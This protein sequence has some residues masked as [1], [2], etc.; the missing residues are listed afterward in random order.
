MRVIAPLLTIMAL[1]FFPTY[2]SFGTQPDNLI[3][4][5]LSQECIT[6]LKAHLNS[7]CPTYKDLVKYDNTNQ[8]AY[9]RFIE[10]GG[11]FHRTKAIV[12][13]YYTVL[14]PQKTIIAVDPESNFIQHA[15]MIIVQSS[16]SFIYVG[17]AETV[18]NNTRIEYHDR[19]V[20]NCITAR[21][22]YSD[23]MVSDTITY[24]DSGCTKTAI[25][26][27]V[28]KETPKTVTDPTDSPT[29]KYQQWL[30][31]AKNTS[32]KDCRYVDCTVSSIGKKW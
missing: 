8:N 14:D 5:Q 9:G 24:L 6:E 26:T 11:F 16:T 10:T 21:I 17:S 23:L 28:K 25:N 27:I 20:D 13:N 7:T 22:A 32:V 18:S 30:K 12:P 15:K 1:I 3:G 2:L 29:W 19:Y 4:I 31:A